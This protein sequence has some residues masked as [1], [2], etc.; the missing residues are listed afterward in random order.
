MGAR[1]RLAGPIRTAVSI[2]VNLLVKGEYQALENITDGRLLSAELLKRAVE[3]YP[4]NLVHPPGSAFDDLDVVE[5]PDVEP[6]TF[7]VVF[8][9]WTE[10]EGRSDLSLEIVL[11]EDRPGLLDTQISGLHVL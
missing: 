10:E 4:G 2:A 5:A 6:P 7:H 11:V 1:E 9:L 8:D 3:D